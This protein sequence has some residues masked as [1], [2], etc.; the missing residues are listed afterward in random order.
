VRI[1]NSDGKPLDSVF[2]ALSDEEAAELAQA[3]ATLRSAKA[4]WHEHVTDAG[5]R[6]EITVYREDDESAVF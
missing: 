1:A 4:G 2:L 6:R 3:L 5:G